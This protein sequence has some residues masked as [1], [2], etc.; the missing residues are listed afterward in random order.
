[1]TPLHMQLAESKV[2]LKTR[3]GERGMGAGAAGGLIRKTINAVLT[4][5][6]PALASSHA[7][8]GQTKL[9]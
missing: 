7:A 8:N 9:W 5:L 2:A 3:N 6:S 4:G 1:M